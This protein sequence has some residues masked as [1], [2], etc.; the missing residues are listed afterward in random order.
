MAL[1][2]EKRGARRVKARWNRP[3]CDPERKSP[4]CGGVRRDA[5]CR[6]DPTFTRASPGLAVVEQLPQ[7]TIITNI[8]IISYSFS[9]IISLHIPM[10]VMITTRLLHTPS[11]ATCRNLGCTVAMVLQRC[12]CVRDENDSNKIIPT[13][14][15]LLTTSH[16]HIVL[17]THIRSSRF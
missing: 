11:S 9:T 12:V 3:Y 4:D 2:V 14:E 1:R 5:A 17:R 7:I 13:A 8:V 16:H 10:L 6:S 15:S